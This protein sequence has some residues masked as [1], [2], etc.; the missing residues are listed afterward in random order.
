MV[1]GEKNHTTTGGGEARN[2][3]CLNTTPR[4]INHTPLSLH[5]THPIPHTPLSFQLSLTACRARTLSVAPCN[6]GKPD[7]EPVGQAV[8]P[9]WLQ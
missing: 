5:L 2:I 4:H 7:E 1:R 3:V 6:S 8:L 9:A